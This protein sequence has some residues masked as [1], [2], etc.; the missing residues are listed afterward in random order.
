[1]EQKK[2]N[3]EYLYD[4]FY[5]NC[6]TRVRDICEEIYSDSLS[7]PKPNKQ[8]SLRQMLAEKLKGSP[9][10][11]LGINLILGTDAD[12]QANFRQQM[13]LPDYL[14]SNLSQTDIA[15]SN[16]SILGAPTQYLAEVKNTPVKRTFSPFDP[17]LVLSIVLLLFLIVGKD[18]KARQ[19]LA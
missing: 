14:E 1:M 18:R 9:W 3:R 17:L 12:R 4:F 16:T 7:Y 10:T 19:K 5:D 2:E 8:I 11:H 15:S 13:F 6:A